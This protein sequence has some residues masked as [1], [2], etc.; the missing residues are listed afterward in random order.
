MS[1]AAAYESD[2]HAWATEQARLLR[3]GR[4][5]EADLENIAEELES[6]GRSER[7]E[8]VSRLLTFTKVG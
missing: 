2:F 5:S 4:V 7:R 6:M 1:N 8:L 3:A